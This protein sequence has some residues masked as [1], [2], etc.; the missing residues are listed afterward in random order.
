MIA[1]VLSLFLYGMESLR[2]LKIKGLH[3]P[4]IKSALFLYRKARNGFVPCL[5]WERLHGGVEKKLEI[6]PFFDVPFVR[7]FVILDHCAE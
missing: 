6:H 1:I 7:L 4:T 3:A 5:V 2:Y